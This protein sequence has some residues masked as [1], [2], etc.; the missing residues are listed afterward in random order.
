[1]YDFTITQGG[2]IRD[3]FDKP[4]TI[5]FDV[6]ESKVTDPDNIEI[7]YYDEFNEEWVSIGGNYEGGQ[8]TAET[9]HFT[10][11]T[12]FD[13]SEGEETPSPEEPSEEEPNQDKSSDEHELP[14]TAKSMYNFLMIGLVLLLS[15]AGVF[16]YTRKRK[17]NV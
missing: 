5:T 1:V 3:S 6:D 4:I 12:T 8:V 10:V 13:L 2:T 16:F 14:D 15:G 11:F 17:L 9:D 7:Y